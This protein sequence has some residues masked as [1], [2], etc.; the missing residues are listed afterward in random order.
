AVGIVLGQAA[1]LVGGSLVSQISAGAILLA[2]GIWVFALVLRPLERSR[3]TSAQFG[4]ALLTLFS[5]VLPLLTERLFPGNY[6]G[7]F[8]AHVIVI[9]FLLLVDRVEIR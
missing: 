8:S 7:W 1:G 3:V 5:A 9:L 2:A 4:A 6:Q